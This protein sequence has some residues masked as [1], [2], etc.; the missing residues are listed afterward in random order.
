MAEYVY[1][2]NSFYTSFSQSA[3]INQNRISE[4]VTKFTSKALWLIPIC[5]KH[6]TNEYANR[7]IFDMT[8]FL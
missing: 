6:S 3:V 1:H 7:T 5:C 2:R 8:K 4:A